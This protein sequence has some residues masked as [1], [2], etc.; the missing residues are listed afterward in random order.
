MLIPVFYTLFVLKERRAEDLITT[1]KIEYLSK[2]RLELENSR[3]QA[4]GRLGAKDAEFAQLARENSKLRNK[5]EQLE[6]ELVS[7]RLYK[8][9]DDKNTKASA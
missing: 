5:I 6:K 9:K 3:N 4:E 8:E 7:E 1:E 2:L